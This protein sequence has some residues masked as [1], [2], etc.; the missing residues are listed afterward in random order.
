MFVILTFFSQLRGYSPA[1]QYHP[2]FTSS[3]SKMADGFCFLVYD[4][5]DLEGKSN[6][7][8]AEITISSPLGGIREKPQ[9]PT[10]SCLNEVITACQYLCM[11]GVQRPSLSEPKT[12]TALKGVPSEFK[13]G[14]PEKGSNHSTG[15][16]KKRKIIRNVLI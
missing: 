13:G 15:L 16:H 9:L 14:V 4:N 6:R 5:T 7:E 3:H 2:F 1:C 10:N 8:L 11:A 12:V